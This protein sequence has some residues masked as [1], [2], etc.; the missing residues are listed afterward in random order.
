MSNTRTAFNVSVNLAELLAKNLKTGTRAELED[1]SRFSI[2]SADGGSGSQLSNLNW[3][4]PLTDPQ[5]NNVK[6]LN[7]NN[8]TG[9][10]YTLALVDNDHGEIW[11]K[12]ALANILTIPLNATVAMP[13]R[14]YLV[15]QEGVGVTT[16]TAVA[17]VT[18]NGIDG[19]SADI[20]AQYSGA[21]ITKRADNAWVITG[22]I[23]AVS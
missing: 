8:Q 12:N 22:A 7:P 20:A 6:G 11:M 16:I 9:T 23:G 5:I 2:D 13:K 10:A 21:A 1:G 19:G 14:T 4:N 18:L 17:G 15:T 3:A